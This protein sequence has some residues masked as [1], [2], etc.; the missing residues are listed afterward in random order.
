MLAAST[1][2]SQSDG[3]AVRR[4]R[5]VL[6]DRQR[7]ERQQQHDRLEPRRA[8]QVT[9]GEVRVDV[10]RE[11]HGL[12]EHHRGRPDRLRAAEERQHHPRGHRLDQEDER[13]AGEHRGPEDAEQERLPARREPASRGWG[14]NGVLACGWAAIQ[15]R[16][17]R[18]RGRA[19]PS[20]EGF[21]ALGLCACAST[22]RS[23]AKWRSCRRRRR[24]SAC[25]SAARPSTADPR[26]QRAAV[27]AS[28]CG[29][30]RWLRLRGY[31]TTLVDNITDINDKIYEAAPGASAAARRRGD[32]VVPRGHRARSGSGGPTTSR[33]RPRR[34]RPDRP[35]IDELVE[36]GFAYEV[37]GDVYFRVPSFPEY[38]R[39]SRPA[40]RPGGGAGAEPAQG[41]SARLRALEGE[42]AGR[43]HVVGLAVGARPAGLAHRVLGDGGE[44]PRPRVR[45]PRR[46][47]RPRLPAPRERDRAVA[48]ARARVR[49]HLDAQRH[50]P[51]HGREDAQV[52]RQ[53]RRR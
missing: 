7:D 12:E 11:E 3:D 19:R 23:P 8:P 35:L 15:L 51:L 17:R 52:A 14:S 38:G 18:P 20:F 4:R 37:D 31:E 42:Q 33:R 45:D 39:L 48:R 30:K 44:A 25:T 26:R 28:R 32:A 16:D 53:R 2:T 50:A 5:E 40:A 10:P 6:P 22:T 9:G 27:R 43:G 21:V 1:P 36:G 13:R 49:A 47:P 34:A 46:R 29:C 24:G 41:G